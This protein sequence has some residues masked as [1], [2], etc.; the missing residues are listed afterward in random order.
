MKLK[1]TGSKLEKEKIELIKEI[2]AL[3]QERDKL[4]EIQ[5]E[6][7]HNKEKLANLYDEGVIDENGDLIN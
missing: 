7:L 3:T 4:K 6:H 2:N 1:M 5:L